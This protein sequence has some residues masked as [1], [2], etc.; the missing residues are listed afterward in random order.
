M[1]EAFVIASVEI[2]QAKHLLLGPVEDELLQTVETKR[3]EVQVKLAGKEMWT[4]SQHGQISSAIRADAITD[5][6]MTR[7]FARFPDLFE[8]QLE[9]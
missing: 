4:G 2:A 6:P 9:S 1:Q 5:V 8:K 3:L 7:K